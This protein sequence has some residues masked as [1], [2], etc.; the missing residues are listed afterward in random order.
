[1]TGSASSL[2][3]RIAHELTEIHRVARHVGKDWRNFLNTGDD[4]YLKATV[5]DLHGFYTG[6]ERVF[7]LI[8]EIID[9]SLPDGQAWHKMLLEE[10]AREV[11]GVRPAVISGTTLELLDEYLRFRHLIRNVYSFNLLPEKVRP[12]VE[13]LPPALDQVAEDISGFVSLFLENTSELSP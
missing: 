11:E 12:L 3:E 6:V 5:F 8:A 2:S 7:R 10:M 1:M 13:G 9:G 4:G